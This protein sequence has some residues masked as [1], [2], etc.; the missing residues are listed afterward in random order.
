M[1][2]ISVQHIPKRFSLS[3]S[4]DLVYINIHLAIIIPNLIIFL[5]SRPPPPF[6]QARVP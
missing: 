4:T 6:R 5:F 1:C 2:W 3:V